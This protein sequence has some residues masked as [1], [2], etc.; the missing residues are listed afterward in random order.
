MNNA[1]SLNCHNEVILS[2]SALWP[3]VVPSDARQSDPVNKRIE[4]ALTLKSHSKDA[5]LVVLCVV[6]MI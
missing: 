5:L 6:L 2:D 3:C 1:H 4:R